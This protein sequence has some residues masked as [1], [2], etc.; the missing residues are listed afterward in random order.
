AVLEAMK[1]EN[2]VLAHKDGTVTGL[3]A[4]P[5]ATLTQGS[6]LCELKD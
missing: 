4:Q 1:M 5:G 3:T 2:P 6:T